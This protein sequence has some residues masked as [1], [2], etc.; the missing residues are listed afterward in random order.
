MAIVVAGHDGIAWRQ[1]VLVAN[2]RR[3][4]GEHAFAAVGGTDFDDGGR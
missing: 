1:S 2:H 4:V 3:D